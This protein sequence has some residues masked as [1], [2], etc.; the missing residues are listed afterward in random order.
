MFPFESV[1]LHSHSRSRSRTM[2][3]SFANCSFQRCHFSSGSATAVDVAED[4]ADGVTS[5]LEAAAMRAPRQKHTADAVTAID[6]AEDAADALPSGINVAAMEQ[7]HAVRAVPAKA[8]PG[9]V[10]AKSLSAMEQQHTVQAGSAKAPLPE[11]FNMDQ[12][13]TVQAVPA[14][15]PPPVFVE[16]LRN[17]PATYCSACSR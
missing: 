7:Q 13:H 15:A 11:F 16:A 1:V 17:G 6:M 12:Q 5:E 2:A 14:K 10:S 8:F 9:K 4:A 3:F